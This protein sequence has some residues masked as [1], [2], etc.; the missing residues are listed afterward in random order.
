MASLTIGKKGK[1]AL[2]HAWSDL[3]VEGVGGGGSQRAS[4][5]LYFER[6]QKNIP[7]RVGPSICILKFY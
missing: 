1:K 6:L 5:T 7:L 3:T 4:H 2:D